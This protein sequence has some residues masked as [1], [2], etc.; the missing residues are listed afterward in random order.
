MWMIKAMKKRLFVDILN[1]FSLKSN[2]FPDPKLIPRMSV[3]KKVNKIIIYSIVIFKNLN[4]LNNNINKHRINYIRP[5]LSS[6][7]FLV[8]FSHRLTHS[9][10]ES[11]LAN[12]ADKK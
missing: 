4:K 2:T 3:I 9:I 8:W 5:Q 6:Q 10:F 7:N 1:L 12:R 11:L